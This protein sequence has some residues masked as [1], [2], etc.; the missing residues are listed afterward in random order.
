MD[1]MGW[2]TLAALGMAQ[3]K[4]C[5]PLKSQAFLQRAKGWLP[6]EVHAQQSIIW[7]YSM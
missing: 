4:I 7:M 3:N 2:S 1:N 5:Q 6:T